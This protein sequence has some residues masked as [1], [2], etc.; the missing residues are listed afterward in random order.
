[1][2][3]GARGSNARRAVTLQAVYA[4]TSAE[5][6]IAQQLAA[7]QSTEFIAANRGVAVGTVRAQIKAIMAKIGVSR[8]VELVVRLSQL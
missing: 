3:R 7:G 8:Q 4:L 6:E 2:A 5:S 1:V